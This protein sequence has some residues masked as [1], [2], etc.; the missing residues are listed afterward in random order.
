M[1]APILEPFQSREAFLAAISRCIYVFTGLQSRTSWLFVLTSAVIATAI[2]IVG[3]R[4]RQVDAPSLIRFLLPRNVYLHRSA[5]VDYKYLLFDQTVAI[6][7]YSPFVGALAFLAY[8][9][10]NSAFAGV[11]ALGFHP[12]NA[13]EGTILL[14]LVVVLAADFAFFLAHYL[15]HKVPVLWCFHQVHHSAEVLTPITGYRVHPVDELINRAVW[16]AFTGIG[17]ALYTANTAREVSLPTLLG[18]NIIQFAFL[19]FAFQLRHSHIWLS[20]G[21]VLSRIFISPAQHQ[22]HHSTEAR[23]WDKNF[24]F[25]FAFWDTLFRSL[26][27]PAGREEFATGVAGADQR[28]FASLPRL[29]LLPFAKATRLAR[30]RMRRHLGLAPARGG[31]AQDTARPAGRRAP[32]SPS[33]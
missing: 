1:L 22:I 30:D 15:M 16:G 14:P 26:Y 29:Y 11:A 12:G 6:V 32:L 28:D 9:A 13:L 24:G 23:H 10:G 25:I 31:A 8:K 19:A 2:Y 4:R 7:L 18:L 5:I 3:R 21:P 33:G 20:Y 17:A 27:V